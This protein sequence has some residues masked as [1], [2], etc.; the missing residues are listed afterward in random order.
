[1]NQLGYLGV[2]HCKAKTKD[3]SGDRIGRTCLW[4]QMGHE[5]VFPVINDASPNRSQCKRGDHSVMVEDLN[6][7]LC[8]QSI[9]EYPHPWDAGS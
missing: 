3:F 6:L 9:G 5:Y 8:R 7:V 1:M 2:P 4:P